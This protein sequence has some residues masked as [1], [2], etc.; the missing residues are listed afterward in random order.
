MSNSS[1]TLSDRFHQA[2]KLAFE[3]HGRDARKGGNIPY[4]SHLMSVCVLVQ[5]D[6]GDEDEAIAALLHDALEDKPEQISREQISAQFG[7]KVLEIIELCTDT[8]PDFIGGEKPAWRIRKEAYLAHLRTS[9]INK[10]RITL[11]DKVDNAR[12]IQLDLQRIGDDLW[13]RFN[14]G[15]EDQ[16]WYYSSVAA[17]FRER[18]IKSPLLDELENLIRSIWLEKQ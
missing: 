15:Q 10:L 18:G 3:L 11:A 4:F 9:P 13:S 8:P 16:Y 2:L 12:S 6:G 5:Q 17:T 1:K 14:A 7:E